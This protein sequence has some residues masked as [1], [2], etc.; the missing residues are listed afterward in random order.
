MLIRISL[1][2]TELN[3]TLIRTTCKR[4]STS[5]RD[6]VLIYHSSYRSFRSVRNIIIDLRQTP[7]GASSTGFHWQAAQA[8]SLINVVVEMSTDPSTAHQGEEDSSAVVQHF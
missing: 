3:G 8:T 2:E 4:S 5:P 7:A 6:L 1:A